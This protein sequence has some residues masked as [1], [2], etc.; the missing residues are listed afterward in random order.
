MT[1]TLMEIGGGVRQKWDVIGRKG[2]WGVASVLDVQFL[3]FLLKKIEFAPW[4]DIT[5]RQT[6]ITLLT[7]N[8][9]FDCDVRQ[10]R[11]PLMISLHCLWAKLNNRMWCDLVLILFWF[12]SF[13]CTVSFG[14]R[15]SNPRESLN[16]WKLK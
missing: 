6:L 1:S 15:S 7:K 11:H 14:E 10:W 2:R 3:F 9:P 12:R 5:L 13:T 8:L 4:P 16:Q